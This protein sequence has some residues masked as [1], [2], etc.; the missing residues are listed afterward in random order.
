MMVSLLRKTGGQLFCGLLALVLPATVAHAA[1]QELLTNGDF[2]KSSGGWFMKDLALQTDTTNNS[3][4]AVKLTPSTFYTFG[5]QQ[6]NVNPGEEIQASVS[7]KLDNI[8]GN[9]WVSVRYYNANGAQIG[10]LSLGGGSGSSTWTTYTKKDT[11]PENTA[12]ARFYAGAL[13]VK[14]GTAYMDDCSLQLNT[15]TSKSELLTNGDFES[16]KTDWSFHNLTLQTT[17]ISE[18]TKAVKLTPSTFYTFGYQQIT[19]TPGDELKAS[20][21]IKLHDIAGKFW[22]SVRYYDA[23][24]S[25]VGNLSLGGG[26][27]S[28]A[29]K[30]YSATGAVPENTAY[31]RFYAGALSV[32]G[33]V[34]YMDNCSL[35]LIS[36]SADGS[37]SI[38]EALDIVFKD[39]QLVDETTNG[40]LEKGSYRDG[41]WVQGKLVLESTN[42]YS[43]KYAGRL[44]GQD[45]YT[46]G[47]YRQAVTPGDIY[48]FSCAS[49]CT[50][51]TNN[52][53]IGIRLLSANGEEIK[54]ITVASLIG[55]RD[56]RTYTAPNFRIPANVAFLDIRVGSSKKTAG[57]KTYFDDFKLERNTGLPITAI[58]TYESVG[59]TVLSE[60]ETAD[61]YIYFRET[62]E[63]QWHE[64]LPPMFDGDVAADAPEFR[65]SIV[66]LKPDTDY[67][68]YAFVVEGETVTSEGGVTFHTWSESPTIGK[69]YSVA[70][71]YAGGKLDLTGI[72][73]TPDAWAKIKGTG[74]N[75]VAAGYAKDEAIALY[76]NQYVILENIQVT[77]GRRYGIHLELCH[78]VRVSNCSISGWGRNPDYFMNGRSYETEA[79]YEAKFPINMDGGIFLDNSSRVTIERSYLHDPRLSANS[80]EYGHPNGPE[81]VV[82]Q[83]T[84]SSGNHVVRYNDIIGSDDVR[85]NDGIE[86]YANE[87]VNG[88][89]AR[90]SDIYGNMICYGQDDVIELDGGQENVR[91]FGNKGQDF[92]C[93]IS[94]APNRIGPSYLFRNAILNLG[95]SQVKA[96]VG[97]A[98]KQGGGSSLTHGFTY[99]FNNTFHTWGYGGITGVGAGSQPDPERQRFYAVSRN[100]IVYNRDSDAN[101]ISDALKLT[102][103]D[104]DFD[105]LTTGDRTTANVVYAAGQ[106]SHGILDNPPLFVDMNSSEYHDDIRLASNSSAVDAGVEVPNFVETYAGAA[107]DQGVLERGSS[108]LLPIRPIAVS[109]DHYRTVL[110]ATAGGSSSAGTVKLTTGNL[111]GTVSYTVKQNN[112]TGWLKVSPT[113]GTLSSNSTKSFTFSVNTGAV[114][115]GTK[116][117]AVVL[118]RLANGYS[119]PLTVEAS[120]K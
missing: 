101:A 106:E 39:Q 30:T 44:D 73:G 91:F 52:A 36:E 98:V 56:W 77:G 89:F 29:W 31:A 86:G 22:V 99:L 32:K 28:S 108:S 93:G 104:F 26:S 78:E 12:Y 62:G 75:D 97:A 34:A 95:D 69:T 88:S 40:G 114:K 13:G 27:G 76:N 80:W 82:V 38:G 16:G 66:N 7:V 65:G 85:W 50:N 120:I 41:G 61:S 33:G 71:L 8:A 5:Y 68:A 2:E 35:Q 115:A 74:K 9:F 45:F 63:D 118:V 116:R 100:N 83:N 103:N 59:L 57:G 49:A 92:R 21:D 84:G 3:A 53:S 87:E 60:S 110:N 112:T 111:G 11:V 119:V 113:S 25:Q 102:S 10:D 48:T 17:E 46:F 94:V 15:A 4:K 14:G 18:G 58:P 109:A 24:G 79:D 54:T 70:E 51:L 6:I 19:V 64:A 81:G 67:Q 117:K 47:S 37:G 42:V 20:A 72:S 23:A 107:P 43:G 1:W 105:N 96:G 55:T 90:D